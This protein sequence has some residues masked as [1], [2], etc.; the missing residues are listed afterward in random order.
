MNDNESY[1]IICK[2][3]LYSNNKHFKLNNFKKINE[4]REFYL[5]HDV[6]V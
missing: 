2:E 1:D 5:A 3:T 6:H 4:K